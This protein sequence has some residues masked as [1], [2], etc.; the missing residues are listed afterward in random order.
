MPDRRDK[1]DKDLYYIFDLI[2]S[3]PKM[4]DEV[5]LEMKAIQRKY[6]RSWA[7][8]TIS[9]LERYFPVSGGQGPMLVGNQYTGEMPVETFR[10][11]VL[12]VFRNLIAGLREG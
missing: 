2:D 11:Y 4:M 10:N 8:R 9:N 3:T 12:R 7:H 1:L 5:I 6:T